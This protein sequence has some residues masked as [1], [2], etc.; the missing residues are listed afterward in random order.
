MKTV[1]KFLVLV[2]TLN[3]ILIFTGIEIQG[4][5]SMPA[6]FVQIKGGTFTMGSPANEANREEDEVQYKVT[7]SSFKMSKYEIT[8]KEY[9]KVM[10][11]NPSYFKG[12]NLPVEQVSW[13]DAITY[14]NKRSVR[15]RLTPVYTINGEDV[16]WN[17]NAN[18]YRLPTEAEWEYACRAGTTTPFSTGNNITTEHID[19]MNGYRVIEIYSP[20]EVIENEN[21]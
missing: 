3:L 20:M 18:G 1:S 4:Q 5:N 17:R 16:T 10:E 14:C 9:E 15:E 19:V 11:N 2:L 12:S 21:D 8:Q 7:V 13:Y 6:N